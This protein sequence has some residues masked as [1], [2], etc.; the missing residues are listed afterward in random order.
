MIR[1][2]SHYV[3]RHSMYR[4][5]SDLAFLLLSMLVVFVAFADRG[6]WALPQAGTPVLTVA[7]S[8]F[9][10]HTASGFYQRASHYTLFQALTR[11]LITLL[12]LLPLT[13]VDEIVVALA[14]RRGGSMPLRELLDC[15]LQGVR[16]STWHPFREDAGPD[17]ASTRL[18]G[19]LI[20]GDGFSQGFG[21]ARVVKRAV[22]HHLCASI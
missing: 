10:A 17:P 20:F 8:M 14:E 6:A 1:I 2:F 9:V 21:C 18:A 15:K 19:W 5:L 4:A 12:V 3:S 11:A 13:Q 7:A 16:V 22:R